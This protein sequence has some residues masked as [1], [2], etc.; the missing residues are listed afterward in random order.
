MQ[1]YFLHFSRRFFCYLHILRSNGAHGKHAQRP[2]N[3]LDNSK[4]PQRPLAAHA[5]N[6]G[7][8]ATAVRARGKPR[9]HDDAIG[10]IRLRHG[11]EGRGGRTGEARDNHS[12][13]RERKARDAL[14]RIRRAHEHP[15]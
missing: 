4:V 6:G 1:S 2:S 15:H 5:H 8:I 13:V 7:D 14:H 10:R 12:A 11:D 9:V 3:A